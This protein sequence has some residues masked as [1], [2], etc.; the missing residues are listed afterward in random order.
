MLSA[1]MPTHP[2]NQMAL[3]VKRRFG[4]LFVT[5]FL[6]AFNDNVFKNAVIILVT[7]R[8]GE[9]L[10]MSTGT[11]VA[12]ASALFILPFFLFSATA[13][14]LADK[15][16]KSRL[17]RLIKAAE[18]VIMFLAMGG[19][20]YHHV[21]LLFVALFLMG[22]HS[23]FFGP[24]KYGILPAH[25]HAK[26]LIGGNAMIEAGTFVAI[27]LGTIVGG[28]LILTDSGP[29]VVSLT[30]IG[31]AVLGLISGW[32][33][34]KATPPEPDLKLDP[35]IARETWR[36]LKSARQNR[37]VFLCI[38]GI[39][40]FWVVGGT[41]LTIFPPYAKDVLHADA[42]VVTLFMTVFTVGIAIGSMLCNRLLKGEVSARLAPLGALGVSVFAADLVFASQHASVIGHSQAM[43]TVSIFL[44][45]F[46]NWRLLADMSLI[47]LCGGIYVVPL[48]AVL[49]E[50]SHVKHRSRMIAANN[51][52]NACFMTV[53][54]LSVMA[55]LGAGFSL[56]IVIVIV[57]ALNLAVTVK[58]CRLLP[59]DAWQ[60]L[61]RA[62]LRLCFRVQVRGLEH[63][64]EGRLLVIANH[65]SYLDAVL[66]A[67]FLP[68]R[69]TFAIND[70][71]A[72][73]WWVKPF[74]NL[75]LAEVLPLSPTNP[76]A[77]KTIVEA[78]KAGH[79]CMIFPEG[80]ITVTGSLM[81]VYEGPGLIA[82]K[83]DVQLVPVRIDGAQYSLFSKLGGKVR[84]QLFP[85][86]TLHVLPSVRLDVPDT[87][88]GRARRQKAAAQL[89]DILSDMTFTTSPWRETLPHA[90]AHAVAVHG[91]RHV[92]ANDVTNRPLSYG[93]LLTGQ[94]VLGRKLAALAPQG[95]YVG[96]MLPNSVAMLVS[97]LGLMAFGRVPALLNFATGPAGVRAA[98][99]VAPLTVVVTSRVF[100]EKARLE[101]VVAALVEAKIHIV[102]LE[103]L[104]ATI[105]PL[106]KAIG[107]LQGLMPHRAL[108]RLSPQ[109]DESPAVLLF[110][111]GSEGQP[112]GVLLSHRNVL[113]NLYQLAARI[114]FGP[115][116]RVLNA[117]PMFHS[118]G[119]TG[120]TLVPVLSG[121]FVFFYPSPLHYRLVPEMAYDMGATILFGTDTFLSGY[122]RFAHP[123]DF[124]TVRY[125]FAGAE[126]LKDDTRKAWVDRF[127]LRVLEGYGAT[128]T[129][130]ALA[131]NTP[132]Q[133]RAGTVGRLLPGIAYRLE[134]VPGIPEG[135][136]LF[137]KGPNVMMGYLKASNPG[138]LEPLADGW[139]DTGDMVTVDDDG[140]VAI[141]GR[142]KRFAK[143]AGEM[144][145]LTRL[146]EELARLWPGVR[147][148]VL[149]LPDDRKGERLALLTEEPKATRDA[150]QAHLKGA[151]LNELYLVKEIR[152]VAKVPLL[153]SGK[154]DVVGAQALWTTGTP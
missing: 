131:A 91:R 33:V 26:E 103:D 36:L 139:Y 37:S 10:G 7:Y 120:G 107:V 137:V 14:Q 51:V 147:H 142:L 42:H 101:P 20:Y 73:K 96:L 13:G 18:V 88:K 8:L 5:Q 125:V 110:T 83:S 1:M 111:S 74:L 132:M 144:V 143:I 112:K 63:W 40:W 135:G 69:L 105:G 3:L 46:E 148:A 71:V 104:R 29:L 136:R 52:I 138:V 115:Q 95:G 124:H 121:A 116:D 38:L 89:Y 44:S 146:E 24:I 123:Y 2:A 6:G 53:A 122:A 140:F 77:V 134:P 32:F 114:D 25:L 57:A 78:S 154:V 133:A 79:T 150:L 93:R 80:R 56:T 66:L 49:Q 84:R 76:M 55:L 21:P 81:K 48:Y 145:S 34:P 94:F 70:Q 129:A 97:V 109:T 61:L 113:A 152:T 50:R 119:L 41:F 16:D 102:Y 30:V 126:K 31:V 9:E 90:V 67:A 68:S 99:A 15:F 12:L 87:V 47:A 17:T 19:F 62:L 106:D 22:A 127:G 4:P 118:F 59:H 86:I 28:L 141:K 60:T 117:L 100:V 128:E 54:A 82:L 39:S 35:N 108:A 43:Q 58:V 45:Y 151:G 23:A 92:V 64:P 75:G 27:L 11:L 72:T 153:P 149:A 98:C 130:P 65:V 85:R